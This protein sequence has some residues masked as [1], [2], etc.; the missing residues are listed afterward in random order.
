MDNC[1]IPI[2]VTK[3]AV[4]TAYELVVLLEYPKQKVAAAF[5]RVG[6]TRQTPILSQIGVEIDRV[7]EL[8]LRMIGT[9]VHLHDLMGLKPDIPGMIMAL[10][11]EPEFVPPG[12]PEEE[13]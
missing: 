6:E 1:S 7:I 2:L 8:A 11:A 13:S 12:A 10:G 9:Q 3:P 4:E 5:L